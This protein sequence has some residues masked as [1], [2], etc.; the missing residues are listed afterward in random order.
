M[1]G[2]EC[3]TIKKTEYRRM[4]AFELLCWRR[5]FRVPWTARRSNQLMLK[6]I[7]PEYSLKGLMLKLKLQNFGHLMRR[8]NLLEKNPMLGKSEGRRRR[9]WQGTRWLDGITNSLDMSLSKFQEM[10]DREAWCTVVYGVAKSQTWWSNWNNNNLCENCLLIWSISLLP[11]LRLPAS[12]RDV[13]NCKFT[14]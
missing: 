10:V 9:R 13:P 4:D 2:Y 12:S 3:W 6:E 8:A 14:S 1:Y 5:L 11:S 7:N